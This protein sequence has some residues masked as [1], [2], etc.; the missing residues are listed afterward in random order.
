MSRVIVVGAGLAGLSCALRLADA[1]VPVT[2]I[3]TGVGSLQLGGATIDV[4]GYAPERVE[5]PLEAFPALGEDHPYS[6]LGAPKVD[7]AV[8]W[9][10]ERLPGLGLRGSASENMLLATAVGAARPTAVA[11][12]AIAGG[13][14]RRGGQV[15]FAS[16]RALKDF[17]PALVAANVARADGVAVEARACDADVA[18][19]GEADVSPLGLARALERSETRR[20]LTK[21]LRER[22]GAVDGGR[23]GL[24]AVLGVD[25]HAEVA[26]AV[27][28]ELGGEVFEVP[29][30]PPS[31]PGIRLYRALTAELRKL[32]AR[33]IVGSTAVAGVRDGDRLAGLEVHVSGRT[34][35]FP[36]DAVVLATGGLATGGI[37]LD[38]DGLR[39]PVLG[40]G[41]AGD[42]GRARY[43][44]AVFAENPVDRAGLRVDPAMRPL[45]A[46]GAVAYPNL[47]AAG[48]LLRGAVPWRE[49]SGN[50][51]A[52]ATGLVA[53]DAISAERAA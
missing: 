27:A 28:D 45:D 32:E 1:G 10:G 42:P 11:P 41:L 18:V 24:P 3:A 31:V 2:V 8:A 6:V 47:Y 34:R 46:D 36:A 52:L 15:A 33:L 40:L 14:L 53:A 39:E 30:P 12:A 17:V 29:T 22:I 4:L 23:I 9:L 21:A 25:R 37:E 48:A 19:E 20:Q 43:G 35:T 5:R 7:A 51:L 13:D 49:L 26:A 16:V 50:G 44:D 38:R